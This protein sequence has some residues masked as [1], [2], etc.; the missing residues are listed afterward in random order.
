M[1]VTFCF[2]DTK[3]L[4]I[5]DITKL[6]SIFLSDFLRFIDGFTLH[7]TPE[8]FRKIDLDLCPLNS[9]NITIHRGTDQI[10]GCVTEYEYNGWRLF[11]DYGEQLPGHAKTVL[12]VE[13]LTHGDLSKSALL[14]THYHCDHVGCIID[15]PEELPIYIG[16]TAKEIL[17]EL[18]EHCGYAD[19]RQKALNARLKYVK[20]FS[21]G[22]ALEWG[23][24][25]IMPIIMD[26][27]AFDAYA[28][29]I[30]AGNLKVFHTGDFRT[31]GFRSGKLP[32]VIEKYVGRVDY[33]VCEAT[34]VCRDDADAKP[35]YELQSEFTKAFSDNKY[36]VVYV[37]S[38]NIDRLFGL[39][40]SALRAHRPFYVDRYQKKMMDIVA[41]RDKIWDKSK[42]YKYKE[43]REPI[44]LQ[45]DGETLHPVDPGAFDT[46]EARIYSREELA[47][48][49]NI[50]SNPDNLII[51]SFDYHCP[52]NFCRKEDALWALR[53][54]VYAP[55]RLAAYSVQEDEHM[56]P[57]DYEVYDTEFNLH[58]SYSPEARLG[59][60]RVSLSP[61]IG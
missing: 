7:S 16:E 48:N 15:L 12:R 40:H 1:S 50:V 51:W 26:H 2:T 59:K 49:I 29:G 43:G 8:S 52:G 34:H 33:V 57:Y 25:H 28:F 47:D 44:V 36:N 18:S 42:L 45:T 60:R 20:T 22:K 4:K 30:E 53:H 41:G 3:I 35:E 10:G 9:Y 11:V 13:G 17:G 39:Y 38:T 31:H 46:T 23:D 55:S 27:S 37:S 32:Q 56:D 58:S 5:F 6:S 14:V 24:F 61:E 54:I 19:E 21:A